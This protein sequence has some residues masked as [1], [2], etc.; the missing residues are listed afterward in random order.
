MKKLWFF[1]LDGT[2]ADTDRDIREAWKSALADM[3]LECPNFD[4]DFVAGPP[5]EEMARALFPSSYTPELG[6]ELRRRFGEHYDNDGF[7]YTVE[8]PGV[9][10]LVRRLKGA[11]ATVVIATNKRYVGARLIAEKFGWFDVFDEICAGDMYRDDPEIGVL[12]KS[13][14]LALLMKRHGACPE[15]CVIVGDTKSDF[16]AARDN[17]IESIGVEW[18]YGS[19]DELAL[20]SRIVAS[21]QDI[22]PAAARKRVFFDATR[23]CVDAVADYLASRARRDASLAESLAHV[24]VI[25][26]TAQSGRRLRLALARRFASGVVPPLVKMPSQL[27]DAGAEDVAGRSDELLAFREARGGVGGFDV[28]AQLS[29]IRVALGARA[30]SFADVADRV[31][32]ILDGDLADVEV[33]RWRDLAALESRY[34]A[35]LARRGKRDRIEVLKEA[36]AKAPELH[37]VEEVVVAC[38]LDPIPLM[39]LVLEKAALPVTELLPDIPAGV[40]LDASQIRPS[41]TAASEAEC[42]AAIFASVKPDEALPSLCLADPDVF[43]ELQGALQ[44]RGIK[45]HNPSAIPLATSSLGHLAS[46]LAALARTSS[47]S[48]FSAF[49]RGGDARRWLKTELKL[50]ESA[51]TAALVDLDNRQQE[52]IPAKIDDIA[53]KTEHALRAIFEFVK[54]QLRKRGIRQLLKSIF[55]SLPIDEHDE[56]AREFAAAAEAMNGLID[57]CFA[58]DVPPDLSLELFERRLAETTYE[59]EPDEG[60]TV[61]ADGWLELPFLDADEVVISGFAEGKV[62]QSIVGHAFLPDSLRRG[63]GIA[64]NATRTER[65]RKILAMTL[66]CRERDAVT[67]HFHSVDSNGDVLKPS[68]LLFD[69]ASDAELAK[70]VKLLYSQRAGTGEGSAADLPERWKIDLPVPPDYEELKRTSPSAIDT[71]MRCPFTY[72]LR[73]TF[74]ESEDYR[75]EELDASE[76][77]NLVHNALEAWGEGEL[78]DSTDAG[79]IADILEQKVDAI[80]VDRFGLEIPAVVALQGE[81]AKRRLRRF[82]SLQASRASEGWKVVATERKMKVVYGHTSVNGRCDRIDFNPKTGR[83]CVIDYKTWDSAERAAAFEMKKDR[84][85]GS[86]VREWKSLQL[87]LYCA[88]LDADGGF[89]DARRDH[90]EA[91]YCVLAKSAEETRFTDPFSGEDVPE[92]EEKV[93]CLIS[94]IERGIFWPAS[95][96]EEYKWD[97][98]HLVFNSPAESVRSDWIEDQ[99]RRL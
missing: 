51:L 91:Q 6:A 52:L 45:V 53:P 92:A 69:C 82:A 77:G 38:V 83:W 42:I 35:V 88:M 75:A 64:D 96:T 80:L 43:T 5:I 30:L 63:L 78:K 55:D 87:P 11:G 26:P 93:R 94:R 34:V 37:G 97:F 90:I 71:Y 12:K 32:N 70:R 39:D 4:R 9:M 19:K 65:D 16:V 18:G 59:L 57:E 7:P 28:A 21:P 17:G 1:D 99:M 24:L 73:K 76:F 56:S 46:Q 47:Y 14:L 79:A 74:K 67:V 36:V 10:E 49:V 40:E 84:Q 85:S 29:D 54:V 41:G 31:G 48:V 2:L 81:S 25:V 68:R 8:Y 3:G 89:P 20:A 22:F 23:K 13:G 33:A 27:V 60:E 61:L 15:D 66:A 86:L 72:L 44:A 58:K 50:E 95:D 62:P 98:M